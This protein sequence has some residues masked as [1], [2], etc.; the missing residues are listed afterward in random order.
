MERQRRG[1]AH[2]VAGYSSQVVSLMVAVAVFLVAVAGVLVS[3]RHAG[4]DPGPADAAAGHVRADG[5]ADLLAVSPGVGWSG[6]ADHVTRLG[7]SATNG[8]GLQQSSLDALRGASYASAANGKVDYDE[9]RASLGLPDG[10][11][12]HIRI[13]PVGMK[14]VY[15]SSLVGL[16]A[17]YI[18]DWI[19]LPALKVPSTTLLADMPAEAD[20]QVNKSMM[21]Q[22]ASERGILRSVGLT[23][24]NRVHITSLSPSAVVD[25]PAPLVDPPLLT[26]LATSLLEG[27][28]YPDQKAYL[29]ANLPGRLARYDIVVVGS[30]VDQSALTS[31]A[32]KGGFRDWVLGGGTLVVLGSSSQNFQWIQP[33]FALGVSTANGA[34]TA[35]DVSHPILKEPFELD[36]PH[37]DNHGLTWDIKDAGAGAHYDDFIHVIVQ[38]GDDVLAVSK[39]GAF[40]AGRIILTTY[41]P[42]EIA[43]TLGQ[44]EATHFFE[45]VALYADHAQLYLDYGPTAPPDTT[46]SVAVRQSWLWDSL[47]GQV[48]VRIE[49]LAWGPLDG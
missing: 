46:V 24:N 15:N 27:D 25:F 42:R 22:T 32:V 9:A 21:A 31:N 17:A 1:L 29:D 33:L 44:P 6:G 39:E 14:A 13:Y 18:G 5:L 7:L 30:G 23:F 38:G 16:R 40:G 8:S 4:D 36:W 48:P 12:F 20:R 34:P 49:V 45:N 10:E 3:I 35:P 37:Y 2:G 47:L 26:Y 28:V 43:S 19:D 11:D 41:M